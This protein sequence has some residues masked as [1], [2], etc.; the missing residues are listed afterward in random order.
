MLKQFYGFSF[1]KPS[2]FI[3]VILFFVIFFLYYIFSY[4]FGNNPIIESATTSQNI[5]NN[6]YVTNIDTKLDDLINKLKTIENNFQVNS[7]NVLQ[8]VLKFGI[9]EKN[10]DPTADPEI[11]ITGTP[12][13]Q[14]INLK[15][16]KGLKGPRGCQ[17][18]PG[19][20]GTPGSKG[21]LGNQGATGLNI[22]PSIIAKKPLSSIE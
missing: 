21:D 14:F 1:T 17:G 7:D 6:A 5:T 3:S 9:I 12:P 8:N 15:L 13:N 2:F 16:P 18:P 20:I 22:N 19:S 10:D 11:Y 4:S